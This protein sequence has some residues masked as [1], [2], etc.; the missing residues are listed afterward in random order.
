MAHAPVDAVLPKPIN[1]HALRM[2]LGLDAPSPEPAAR[3]T[4]PVLDPHTIETIRTMAGGDD[5]M[6]RVLRE[7]LADLADAHHN[8]SVA[9]GIAD[10]PNIARTAHRIRGAAATVGANHIE[11]RC[12]ALEAAAERQQ[13]GAAA[14]HITHLASETRAVELALS[15]FYR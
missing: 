5:F 1:A 13:I 6:D 15:D 2:A 12:T 9:I 14:S 3:Q 11:Q 7:F 10:F 4:E 8:L